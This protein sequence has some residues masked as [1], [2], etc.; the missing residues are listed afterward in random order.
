MYFLFCINPFYGN[1][2]QTT[3]SHFFW[4]AGGKGVLEVW[5]DAFRS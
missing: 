5:F 4:G 2:Y 1:W 3:V